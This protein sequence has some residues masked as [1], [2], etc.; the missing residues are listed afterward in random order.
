MLTDLMAND[1][2]ISNYSPKEIVQAY[3]EI[4]DLAPNVATKQL[5]V[6]S[7]LRKRLQQGSFD[8]FD[9]DSLLKADRRLKGPAS[10]DSLREGEDL[11]DTVA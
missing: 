2:V 3:N 11:E 8:Q 10:K 6:R 9:V 4:Y 7:Y 1:E 5:I